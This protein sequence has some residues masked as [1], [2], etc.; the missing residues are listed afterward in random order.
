MKLKINSIGSK[1]SRTK[2]KKE[3]QKYLIQ[4][5]DKLTDISKK[6]LETNPLRIL[7]TKIDFEIKIIENAPKI[8]DFLDK[9]DK[10]HFQEV[11]DFLELLPTEYLL[12]LLFFLF[13]ILE[14]LFV[15][16]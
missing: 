11:L 6:R 2:Y 10:Q 16:Y 15:L 4:Y 12:S 7:D 8:I 14:L 9:D 1:E 13:H 3:L 5:Q